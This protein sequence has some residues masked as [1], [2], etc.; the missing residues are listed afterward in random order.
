[1][2]AIYTYTPITCSTRTHSS[3]HDTALSF[4]LV[5]YEPYTT[6]GV[7]ATFPL[8]PVFAPTR[9]NSKIAIQI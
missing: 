6:G 7:I 9:H 8:A 2:S 1:M 5:I 4:H 3:Y